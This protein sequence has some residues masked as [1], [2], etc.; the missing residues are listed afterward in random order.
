VVDFLVGDFFVVA[1]FLA[2]SADFF[3]VEVYFLGAGA[4]LVA[5]L[6]PALGASALLFDVVREAGFFDFVAA[7][8][9]ET[10][11]LVAGVF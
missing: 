8:L 7:P 2:V 6:R 11:F 5:V 9:A 4:A 10:G 3:D 1:V